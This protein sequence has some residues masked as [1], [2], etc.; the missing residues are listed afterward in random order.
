MLGEY[1]VSPSIRDVVKFQWTVVS[2]DEFQNPRRGQWQFLNPAADR[3]RH[4]TR[5]RRADIQ[6]RNLAG[7]F[8]AQWP[9][10]RR[11]FKQADL[12]RHY[13]LR[14]RHPVGLK[15]ILKY[16]SVRT[17][18]YFLVQ[19]VTQA[20]RDPALDLPKNSTRI[21]RPA[22]VLHDAIAQHLHVAGFRL[23]RDFAFVNGEHGDIQS[24]NK[25]SRRAAR[26]RGNACACERAASRDRTGKRLGALG[27]G[28]DGCSR[29]FSPDDLD[30]AV[31]QDQIFGI[32]FEHL[33]GHVE[34]L[35]AYF[36]ASRETCG[37]K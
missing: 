26:H 18:R 6:D 27:D 16:A 20:L 13:V 35:L 2:Q 7:S 32:G 4:R 5:D 19:G 9:D 17:D 30:P 10:R 28:R 23:N 3:V 33:R 12:N 21:E 34:Q 31:P 36:A 24:F 22:N 1:V 37:A 8:G 29:P 11:T 25:M 14:E 15:A